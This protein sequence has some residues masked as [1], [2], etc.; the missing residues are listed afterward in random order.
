MVSPPQIETSF[1]LNK[2]VTSSLV[3]IITNHLSPDIPLEVLDH[4]IEIYRVKL[5]LQP[6]QLFTL[7]ELKVSL[8]SAPKYLLYSFL[9]LTVRYSTHDFFNGQQAKVVEFY[10]SSAQQEVAILASQ[11][12]PKLEIVQAL[13]LLVLVDVAGGLM[14]NASGVW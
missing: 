5:H 12:I 1:N 4:L 9:A 8:T 14:P 6:L 10:G 13:C 3:I 11:G 2:Y 7:P